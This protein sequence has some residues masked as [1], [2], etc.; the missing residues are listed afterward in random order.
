MTTERVTERSD[1]VTSERTVE[2]DHGTTVVERRGSGIGGILA[3]VLLVAAIAIAAMF[4]M[5]MNRQN[6]IETA[7]VADAAESV[8]GAADSVADAAR[9]A[10][11]AG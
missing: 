5:N 7:A 8:S 2:R 3:L 4:F 1:G 11:P 6:A 10:V 9:Q